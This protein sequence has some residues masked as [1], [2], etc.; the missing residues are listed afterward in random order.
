MKLD[1]FAIADQALL[2]GAPALGVVGMTIATFTPG[3]PPVGLI[4]GWLA[5][6]LWGFIGVRA[7]WLRYW[8]KP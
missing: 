2:V 4:I 7:T 8:R 6:A 3:N 1:L 5:V